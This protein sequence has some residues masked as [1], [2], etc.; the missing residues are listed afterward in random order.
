METLQRRPFHRL[1]RPSSTV[2]SCRSMAG[3]RTAGLEC[4]HGSSSSPQYTKH[5]STRETIPHL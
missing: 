2:Q 5:A 3:I 4:R 1:G